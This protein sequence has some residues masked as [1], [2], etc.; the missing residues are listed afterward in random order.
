MEPGS[1]TVTLTGASGTGEHAACATVLDG[2]GSG[3]YRKVVGWA[4][5]TPRAGA[6]ASSPVPC[7]EHGR[8][9]CPTLKAKDQCD[10]PPQ[11]CPPCPEAPPPP[12]GPPHNQT[13][14]LDRPFATALDATSMVQ[15]GTCHMMLLFHDNY[16]A[17][18]GAVQMIGD[19][20]VGD[21]SPPRSD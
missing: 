16:Y 6:C 4:R 3:Q 8:T 12:P 13:I 9:F 1:S 21:R 5:G 18:G 2:T 11:Q 17:D 14:T 7:K 10:R 15:L 19:G 20:Q